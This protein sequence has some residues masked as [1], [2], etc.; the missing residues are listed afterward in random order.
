MV[1]AIVTWTTAAVACGFPTERE[2]LKVVYPGGGPCRLVEDGQRYPWEAPPPP[3]SQGWTTVW[4][5]GNPRCLYVC[6]Q[7]PFA[8]K[9]FVPAFMVRTMLAGSIVRPGRWRANKR[10]ERGFGRHS[11]GT[12]HRDV[13]AFRTAGRKG[14][15]RRG[16]LSAG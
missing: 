10:G 5:D 7:E 1:L 15:S 4:T 12:H 9:Y 6:D 11:K 13:T 8:R 14:G 2:C 3:N 16:N